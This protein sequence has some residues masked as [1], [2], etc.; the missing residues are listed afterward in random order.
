LADEL[1]RSNPGL[2]VLYISGSLGEYRGLL[3]VSAALPKPFTVG[4][5]L[6]QVK[7]LVDRSEALNYS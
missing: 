2:P 5:L 1:T 4:E 3:G 6:E 7:A